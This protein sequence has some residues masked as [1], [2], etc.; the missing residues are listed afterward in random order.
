MFIFLGTETTR[1]G[2]AD[3]LCQ[4]AFKTEEGAVVNELFNPG[5]PISIDAMTVHHITNEMVRDKPIFR[6]S[7]T[8]NQLQDLIKSDGNVIASGAVKMS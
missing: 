1:N 7:D 8:W 6:D 3:R 4:I 5:M 2:P